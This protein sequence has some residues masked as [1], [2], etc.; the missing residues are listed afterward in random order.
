MSSCKKSSLWIMI[1][2]LVTLT[3]CVHAEGSIVSLFDEAAKLAFATDN[4]TIHAEADFSLN[5]DVFKRFIGTHVQVGSDICRDV[6]LQT[7]QADGTEKESGYTIL[8]NGSNKVVYSRY[9]QAADV[10]YYVM[11]RDTVLRTSV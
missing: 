3:A 10:Y 11:H 5:G 1:L 2:L 6:L 8:V 7:P 4:V 9:A